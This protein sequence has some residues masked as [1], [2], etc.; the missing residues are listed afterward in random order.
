M[1][2]SSLPAGFSASSGQA[3]DALKLGNRL[4]QLLRYDDRRSMGSAI[5]HHCQCHD[6]IAHPIVALKDYVYRESCW[7]LDRTLRNIGH[8][9]RNPYVSSK[10]T[11]KDL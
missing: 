3:S 1:I 8:R 2:G 7:R 9:C 5:L 11:H 4:S 6:R 10:G